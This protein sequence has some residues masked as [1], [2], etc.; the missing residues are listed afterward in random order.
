MKTKHLLLTALLYIACQHILYAF[1]EDYEHWVTSAYSESIDQWFIPHPDMVQST[2]GVTGLGAKLSTVSYRGTN[3]TSIENYTV[4]SGYT[5][6]DSLIVYVKTENKNI[7]DAM[8]FTIGNYAN[9]EV[10]FYDYNIYTNWT[11]L[12]FPLNSLSQNIGFYVRIGMTS[13]SPNATMIIDNV[14]LKAFSGAYTYVFNNGNF[15]NWSQNTIEETFN[16]ITSEANGNW[17]INPSIIAS[18]QPYNFS[19]TT[20]AHNGNYA[21]KVDNYIPQYNCITKVFSDN[22]GQ[23]NTDHTRVLSGYYKL[24]YDPSDAL[25]VMFAYGSLYLKNSL[26]NI[27]DSVLLDSS[28]TYQQFVFPVKVGEEQDFELEICSNPDYQ[29]MGL[30]LDDLLLN[31]DKPT[32]T[33]N[34]TTNMVYEGD[35]LK[36]PVTINAPYTSIHSSIPYDVDISLLGSSSAT[37]NDFIIINDTLTFLPNQTTDTIFIATTQDNLVEGDELLSIQLNPLNQLYDL[38]TTQVDIEIYDIDAPRLQWVSATTDT[39][40]EYDTMFHIGISYTNP[41]TNN[42]VVDIVLNQSNN[43][44]VVQPQLDS[45][46][47]LAGQTDTFW[48]PINIVNDSFANFNFYKSYTLSLLPR[49]ATTIVQGNNNLNLIVQEEDLFAPSIS[50]LND[51]IT[52]AENTGTIQIPI[53]ISNVYNQD[54]A[55]SISV[56]A[57]SSALY[58]IDYTIDLNQ[59]A[60][61]PAYNNTNQH[62]ILTLTDD[63]LIETAETIELLIINPTNG[64]TVGPIGQT[65]ILIQDDDTPIAGFSETDVLRIEPYPNPVHNI[66]KVPLNDILHDGS[67]EVTIQNLLGEPV[68]HQQVTVLPLEESIPLDVSFL[69]NGSYTIQ[70]DKA[71]GYFFKL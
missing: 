32:I 43:D 46:V 48:L 52:F 15:D 63:Q 21:L 16:S 59:Q 9:E 23:T 66:L 19:K 49:L 55:V 61:F 37:P 58:N 26:G 60:I 5:L 42:A 4:F 1:T 44:F 25:S 67:V 8:S 54:I 28:L 30:Y 12:A 50:F 13:I 70:I 34:N 57:N 39:F 38:N 3:Q 45:I 40:I 69:S 7:S 64:A 11:R 33:L 20:D 18:K 51:S 53:K 6:P 36:I 65:T 71:Y 31:N 22:M 27:I 56:Q 17:L 35:T 10:T 29:N 14:Y 2:T 62:A 47:L 24:P 41:S 68:W